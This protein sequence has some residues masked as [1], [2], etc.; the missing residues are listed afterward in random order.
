MKRILNISLVGKAMECGLKS[1]VD[2]HQTLPATG[3]VARTGDLS[4]LSCFLS[5]NISVLFTYFC[6]KNYTKI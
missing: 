6:I 1:Q 3:C 4:H 2:S 5:S